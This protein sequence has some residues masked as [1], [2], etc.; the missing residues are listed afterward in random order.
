MDV[1]N[2]PLPLSFTVS[3][4]EEFR[5]HWLLI[6]GMWIEHKWSAKRRKESSL[7]IL[8]RKGIIVVRVRNFNFP[9]DL[10]SEFTKVFINRFPD[11]I[12]QC[13]IRKDNNERRNTSSELS[14]HFIS[15]LI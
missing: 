3:L 9:I 2:V 4:T 15:F 5:W 11:F 13:I 12:K 6:E 1:S 7:F 14:L 10:V 8:S